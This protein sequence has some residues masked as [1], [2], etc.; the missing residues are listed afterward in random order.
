MGVGRWEV[1]GRLCEVWGVRCEV[2]SMNALCDF[3]EYCARCS[4]ELQF[5]RAFRQP[6]D[7]RVTCDVWRVTCDVW[8]VTCDV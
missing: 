8:R 5:Q 6:V 4:P 2:R 1:G 3:A 7:G